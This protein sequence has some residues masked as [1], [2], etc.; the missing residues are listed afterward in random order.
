[1]NKMFN[2]KIFEDIVAKYSE[3]IE[4]GLVLK[5]RQANVK[6]KRID[7]LFEDRHGLRLIVELKVGTIK[8]DHVAQLM[9]YEGHFLSSD[10]STTRAMLVVNCVPLNFRNSLN[11]RGFEWKEITISDLIGFLRN[12]EDKA[13]L[14]YFSMEESE[15]NISNRAEGEAS[16][17]HKQECSTPRGKQFF[18]FWKQLLPICNEK[19]ALFRN[20]SPAEMNYRYASAGKSGIQWSLETVGGGRSGIRLSSNDKERDTNRFKILESNKKEIEFAFGELLEWYHRGELFIRTYTQKGDFDDTDTWP[21]MQNDMVDRLIRL[22][23]V[24]RSYL[25]KLP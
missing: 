7:L 17:I 14:E 25:D 8:R 18:L 4:D 3:L 12:K 15:S 9:D 13:F 11:R 19:T 5:N 6:G 10:N 1:M 24:L 20:I 22:E 2:E 21:E 23:K 16:K